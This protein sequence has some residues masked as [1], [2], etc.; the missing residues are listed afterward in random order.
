V[1]DQITSD[2]ALV[3]Q[4]SDTFNLVRSDALHRAASRTLMTEAID[5]C[6]SE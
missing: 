6:N 2:P 1:E 5:K 4:A 3:V